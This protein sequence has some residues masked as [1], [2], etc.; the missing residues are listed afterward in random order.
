M[1]ADDSM[2]LSEL[3]EQRGQLRGRLEQLEQEIRYLES[4]PESKAVNS[5]ELEMDVHT[6]GGRSPRVGAKRFELLALIQ[7]SPGGVTVGDVATKL[8]WGEGLVERMLDLEL[9]QG[10]VT[11][12]T[13]G[14]HQLT[15]DG[16]YHW[17]RSAKRQG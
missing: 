12:N 6:E 5:R 1:P 16:E 2:R 10:L 4:K 17:R 13:L 9:R 14:K 11:K 3:R 15:R 7:R 8:G